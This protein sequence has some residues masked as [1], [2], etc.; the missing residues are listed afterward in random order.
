MTPLLPTPSPPL[1]STWP[2]GPSL[3][4]AASDPRRSSHYFVPRSDIGAVS[5]SALPTN[6]AAI[7]QCAPATPHP[8]CPARSASVDAQPH[9]HDAAAAAHINPLSTLSTTILPYTPADMVVPPKKPLPP[10]FP[11]PPLPLSDH[12]IDDA[13]PSHSSTSRRSREKR[14]ACWMCHKAFD[15]PSTLRKHLLVH[16]GEKAFVCETCKRRFGVLSNLNRHTRRCTLR[17]GSTTEGASADTSDGTE[18]PEPQQGTSPASVSAESEAVVE[19]PAVVSLS[20]ATSSAPAHR[21]RATSVAATVDAASTGGAG[22]PRKRRA[23]RAPS[24]SHWIPASL[25]FFDLTPSK[26]VCSLPLAPVVP[27][28]DEDV[29]EERDSYQCD[30]TDRPYHP[31]GWRGKLPGPGLRDIITNGRFVM[32]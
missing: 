19:G 18:S 22:A 7:S 20:G 29:W 21:G 10:R 26:I 30:M 13:Q 6:A 2:E 9:S 24:P 1:I 14:H 12:H 8:A 25:Q 5:S 27:F 32:L 15:R 17:S 28:K 31:S 4:Q 3:P 11:P 16:T 23:R